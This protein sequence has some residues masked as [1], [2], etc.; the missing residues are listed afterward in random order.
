MSLCESIDTLAMT[1]LDDELASEERR[2]LELHLG[3]C[4][5][6]RIHVDAERV[7]LALMRK[8]LAAPPAS[9]MLKARITRALDAEDKET[10]KTSRTPW[11]KYVLPGSAMM[12]AAAALVVFLGMGVQ[13]TPQTARVS[14]VA[15]EAIRQQTRSLPLEVQGAS[16]GPWLRDHFAPVEPPHFN[17]SA[18]GTAITLIGARATAINGHDAAALQ[19]LVNVGVNRVSLSAILVAGVAEGELQGG[20]EVPMGNL[21]LHVYDANGAPA[22]TYVD[23]NHIG[24]VFTSERMSQQELLAI[25]GMSDLITRASQLR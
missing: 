9:D 13:K 10:A 11:Q 17:D 8:A 23:E 12:A 7:D 5:M 24:Y 1:Y 15:Q 19:Y 25:V 21:V 20:Q 4:Q 6:C 22:V 3:E 2:E 16:T 18:N 14:P